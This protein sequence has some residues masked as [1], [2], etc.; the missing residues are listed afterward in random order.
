MFI[1]TGR[2]VNPITQTN[3]EGI[4][5]QPNVKVSAKLAL[6]TAHLAAMRKVLAKTTEQ[7]FVDELKKAIENVEKELAKSPQ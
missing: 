4:G 3:W 5:V 2:A 7:E 1:A 6:K